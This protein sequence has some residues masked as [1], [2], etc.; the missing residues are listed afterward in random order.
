MTGDVLCTMM[1]PLLMSKI[2]DIGVAT[3]N[4]A[5][6]KSTGLEMVGLALLCILLGGLNAK[7]SAEASQGFAANL[8]KALFDKIQSFSFSNIDQFS[9]PSLVTRLTSDVTQLQNTL[10]MCLRMLL[11][12]PLMLVA[13]LF[14]AV[15]I[16][17]KLSFI[18]AVAIPVLVIGIILVLRS[19]ERLFT[20]MQARIDA[21]NGTVQENLVAIRVV[22]AYVR[23]KHEKAKFKKS[24]DELTQAGINAGNLISMMMPLMMFVMNATMI[25]VIWFGGKMVSAG[26]MGTGAL[27]S[28][29]SYLTE[30]LIS[31]MIFSMIFVMFARAEA[32]AKRVVEV[33]DTKIDITDKVLAPGGENEAAVTKGS[34]E[35]RD[36][37]FR[38][39]TGTRGQDVL[40]KINLKVEPGE[41][42]AIIGGTGSGKTSLVNLIPRLYDVTGGQILVDGVDV[43]D[44]KTDRLR[45]GIGMVLQKNVL[46]SGSIKDN[47]LWGDEHATKEEVEA[48]AASAQADEF[49]KS[50][51]EGYETELGQGGVNVS[52]GQKQRLCIARAML[53]KPAI[54]ILDD[55]TSAV[56]TATEAKIRETF[57]RELKDTTVLMIAQRISS[58][59]EAD[60]IVVLD[61]G[62]IA[63]VGSHEELL[64][65]NAIYRE[66]CE[67]QQE[68]LSA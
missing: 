1:M 67:S 7:F 27:M 53:K 11:R 36:V 16:N 64:S 65:N 9:A 57:A 8:R 62:K 44:Y 26:G 15:N 13:A 17:A 61:D 51:P 18:L 14:F 59:K 22:K 2:V 42:V 56:D 47:L 52:G 23:E 10:L 31:V 40:S 45:A 25:A 20:T 6:I 5:Y 38:Y 48:A 19:A 66:I 54:L 50:F 4:L 49:V 35:F 46:F 60:R 34:I 28:F 68:G 12:A 32:C 30:I 3:K 29:L 37:D 39:A 21:L 43:R 24:N 41:F 58:V 55:S 33:L 63:G